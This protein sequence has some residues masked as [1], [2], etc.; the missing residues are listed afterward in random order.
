LSFQ[1]SPPNGQRP[2]EADTFLPGGR[3]GEQGAE[4]VRERLVDLAGAVWARRVV[5]EKLER[6]RV[7]VVTTLV[8]GTLATGIVAA[9]ARA[10]FALYKPPLYIAIETAAAFAG[11]LAA[12]LVFFRFRR[13]ARLDDLVLTCALVI[14]AVTN[15]LFGIVATSSDGF[16]NSFA[17]WASVAGRVIGA[18]VFLAAAFAAPRVLERP[19]R[20]AWLVLGSAVGLICVVGVTLGLTVES[21]PFGGGGDNSHDA[22][23]ALQLLLVAVF[24]AA[25]IGFVSRAEHGDDE[26]MRWFAVA[27]ALGALAALNFTLHPSLESGWVYTGDVFRLF[28]YAALVAGA[29]REISHYWQGSIDAAL[30]Q[31]RRRIARDLHDGLAQELAFIVRRAART[32][33]EEPRSSLAR[34]ILSAAERA[35]DESRRVIAALSRP[36]DE[37]IE[38]VLAEA[39]KEVADRVGTIAAVSLDRGV[40]VSPDVREALVRIAREA[41]TNA[42]RHGD[43]GIVRIE[44]EQGENGSRPVLRIV[45]D[46]RGFDTTST[47]L[48]RN[49]GF[50]LLSMS[51]RAQ[52]VG[53]TFPLHSRRG[54]GTTV[55]VELP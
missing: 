38:V 4:S 50:G 19:A 46:G 21:A 22:A 28:F 10:H 29:A 32:L 26:L 41:V 18:S 13:S 54:V 1:L 39:V 47:R 2:V 52:A 16:S 51:E 7:A 53:A 25:V 8:V 45:D 34:Q 40:R 42:A 55:E 44:L 3:T 9:G 24:G 43:A 5:F 27:A 31:E 48:R 20:T 17:S 33:Q 35:L 30:L 37:P 15:L 11:F 6:P 14:F 36:L 49:G 12:Y 23:M